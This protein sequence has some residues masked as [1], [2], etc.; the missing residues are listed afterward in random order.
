MLTLLTVSLTKDAKC[1]ADITG[2]PHWTLLPEAFWSLSLR[3]LSVVGHGEAWTSRLLPG[4]LA[5][6]LQERWEAA[7]R[8]C[9]QAEAHGQQA[10][11]QVWPAQ[12]QGQWEQAPS[13][14]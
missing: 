3:G 9:C 2:S 4:W 13:D 12:S 11:S 8:T 6:L 1:M 5:W 14:R 7:Q 10:L